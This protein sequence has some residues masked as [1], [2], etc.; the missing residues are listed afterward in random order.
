MFDKIFGRQ[1]CP[2]CHSV[3]NSKNP[4][5]RHTLSCEVFLDKERPFNNWEDHPLIRNPTADS[6]LIFEFPGLPENNRGEIAYTKSHKD[7]HKIIYDADDP[8][9]FNRYDYG[10]GPKRLKED[11]DNRNHNFRFPAG[12]YKPGL[13]SY[14]LYKKVDERTQQIRKR[15]EINESFRSHVDKSL[16]PPNSQIRLAVSQPR[17]LEPKRISNKPTP[18]TVSEEAQNMKHVRN[19][20][21]LHA[22]LSGDRRTVRAQLIITDLLIKIR[23]DLGMPL[24]PP[25][26]FKRPS[27]EEILRAHIL[28]DNILGKIRNDLARN[29]SIE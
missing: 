20:S 9:H 8:V 3:L 22:K 16:L 19:S 6:K 21:P 10:R 5:D 26:S 14:D 1:R 23:K 27:N 24:P 7:G 29:Q 13:A 25:P 17:R 11:P 4:S 2:A 15:G 18:F 12:F 28:V